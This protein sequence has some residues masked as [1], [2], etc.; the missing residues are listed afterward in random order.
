MIAAWRTN[1]LL[2]MVASFVFCGTAQAGAENTL[3]GVF[4]AW[5][6]QTYT[7]DGVSVCMMWSQPEKAEGDYTDRGEIYVFVTHRPA[8]KQA[9]EIRFEAGYTLKSESE[10]KISIGTKRFSLA[11]DSSTAWLSASGEEA[12]MVRAMR[13]GQVMTVE[14]ISNRGTDT[15]DTYSLLGF[16]AAHRAIDKACDSS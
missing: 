16:S 10:V 3:L 12:K 6:A 8:Q 14:G 2:G 1:L 5:T 9:N 7:E 15:K 11:T 13:A 4:K